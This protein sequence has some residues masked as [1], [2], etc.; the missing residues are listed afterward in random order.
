MVQALLLGH[1]GSPKTHAEN[2]LPSFTAALEAGLD[3]FELDVQRTLDGVLVTHH[4]FYLKDGRL[5]AALRFAELPG[6]VPKLEDVLRFALERGAYVNVEIKL[7]SLRTDGRERETV[8][9]I[10]DLR[11]ARQTIISSFNPVS[12]ARVRFAAPAFE[13]ALLYAPGL[14]QWYLKDGASAPLLGVRAIHPHFSQVT[15]ELVQ[16]AHA[17]GWRVNT[18]TVNDLPTAKR[19]L[20]TGVDALIGDYPDVLLAARAAL[21]R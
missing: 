16:R 2:T 17:R 6:D 7:E 14:T 18:W 10:E 1:R 8:A 15:T 3:G 11:M 20:E 5:I 13:T 19:L 12:L 4:D 9:L 21:H